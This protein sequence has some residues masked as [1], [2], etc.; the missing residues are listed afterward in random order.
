VTDKVDSWLPPEVAAR[1][2]VRSRVSSAVDD[3]S[4]R[5][6]AR[7]RLQVSALEAVG[8]AARVENQ[9]WLVFRAGVAVACGAAAASRVTN[10]A[11]DLRSDLLEPTAADQDLTAAFRGRMLGDLVQTVE[12]ALGVAG[13]RRSAPDS[14]KNPFG[15]TGGALAT[16]SDDRG[17]ALLQLAIP[18]GMVMPLCQAALPAR[19]RSSAP[20]SSRHEAMN[21]EV[22]NVE[23][24]LGAAEI[25]LQELRRLTAGDIIVLDRRLG[26][27]I[28]LSVCESEEVVGRATLDE[29]DGQISLTLHA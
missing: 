4:G 25:P 23:A 26:D 29:V 21:T 7:R 6:F 13:S 12:T 28:D 18:L 15:P 3:W 27:L 10:W 19:S 14:V 11:L 9:G 24:T 8:G 16:L 17:S 5:W 1:D 2:A 20:L 22:V